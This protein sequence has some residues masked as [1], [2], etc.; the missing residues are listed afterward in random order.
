MATATAKIGVTLQFGNNA[1][2]TLF[3]GDVITGLKYTL[4][5][6]E[7]TID[8]SVRVINAT[9]RANNTVPDDCPPE[10]YVHRYITVNSLT[11][12]S[13]DV[14]DAE[15]NRILVSAI[16]G[17]GSVNGEN[18]A[19]AVN[20]EVFE[21]V[22]DAVL[23][24]TSGDVITLMHDIEE[25]IT[26]PAGKSLTIEG[27]G[28]TVLSGGIT[29]EGN[30]TEPMT[31]TLKNLTMDGT[32][33]E[34][35]GLISQNETANNQFELSVDL[36]NVNFQNFE[37]KAI[38]LT[39]A[40]KFYANNCR[41]TDGAT[42]P[43]DDPNTVGD[44]CIDLNLIA[45]KDA[46]IKITSCLFE[47]KCGHNATIKIA[48]RGGP[49][50]QAAGIPVDATIKNAVV[51]NCSFTDDVASVNVNIGT[52]N[53]SPAKDKQNITGNFPATIGPN[54]SATFI[55]MRYLDSNVQP[56]GVTMTVP[57]GVA[58]VKTANTDFVMNARIKC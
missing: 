39:N 51:S 38:Y 22:A 41:I 17:I 26:I 40:K 47:G 8:G 1:S 42:G 55:R 2:I 56:D 28:S 9:T 16:T 19:C 21:T 44:Y 12:D 3:E 20:G 34:G 30:G 13:S 11:I 5:G 35:F 57:A 32:K 15:M 46:D 29:V 23:A 10:P 50:D 31:L 14:Y 7:K 43:M 37:K 48:Q 45:V 58:A 4:N 24:A 52:A 6:V 33:S 49:S 27:T 36:Q 25:N 18:I 54:L 53:N